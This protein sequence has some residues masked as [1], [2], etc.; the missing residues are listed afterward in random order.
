MKKT[1]LSPFLL[2]FL[3]STLFANPRRVLTCNTG[4][5][6]YQSLEVYDDG[7]DYHVLMK[8]ETNFDFYTS[9]PI[10]QT[11]SK[12]KYT[13][14]IP[15]GK[16]HLEDSVMGCL[17]WGKIN[18]FIEGEKPEGA[19]YK[20]KVVSKR[21]AFKLSEL[22]RKEIYFYGSGPKVTKSN[23][24]IASLSVLE[25]GE[26]REKIGAQMEFTKEQCR[27]Y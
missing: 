13:F 21:L 8:A 4:G 12:G 14:Q 6:A 11:L 2:L 10:R 20:K 25:K 16:C 23:P 17:S 9:K 22:E 5:F 7:K 26:N 18:V 15:K 24:F 19:V 3:S 27:F 1:L